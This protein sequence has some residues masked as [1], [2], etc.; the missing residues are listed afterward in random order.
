MPDQ[1]KDA[2]LACG[3]QRV[4]GLPGEDWFAGPCRGGLILAEKV[5]SRAT[6]HLRRRGS[7]L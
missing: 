2:L 4:Y 5:P 7:A 1:W 6:D 3:Y